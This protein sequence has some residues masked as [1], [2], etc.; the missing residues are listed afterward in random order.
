MH[1]QHDNRAYYATAVDMMKL[2]VLQDVAD[3]TS[4][5]VRQVL[6]YSVPRGVIK[7]LNQN[8]DKR[9]ISDAQHCFCMFTETERGP[10]FSQYS[11]MV[12]HVAS[13]MPDQASAITTF[14]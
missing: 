8:I 6:E 12:A 9:S 5:A 3:P 1:A 14:P 11:V 4:K 10:G 7:C 2:A 13:R